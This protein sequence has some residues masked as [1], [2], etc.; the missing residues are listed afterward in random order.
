MYIAIKI[1]SKS[2]KLW[3]GFILLSKY[4]HS[5]LINMIY[6]AIIFRV[7]LSPPWTFI[8]LAPNKQ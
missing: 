5:E 8:G 7:N 4:L 6:L 2:H 1:Y 3:M